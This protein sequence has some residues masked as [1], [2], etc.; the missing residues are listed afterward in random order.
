M[1][2]PRDQDATEVVPRTQWVKVH[3]DLIPLKTPKKLG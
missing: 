3:L 1:V 2:V